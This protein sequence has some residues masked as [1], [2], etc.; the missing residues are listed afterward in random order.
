MALSL[1][2]WSIYAI[3]SVDIFDSIIFMHYHLCSRHNVCLLVILTE[4]RTRGC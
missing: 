4:D 3:D 1:V 2:K